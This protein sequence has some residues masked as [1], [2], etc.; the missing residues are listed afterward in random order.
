MTDSQRPLVK[1]KR[2]PMWIIMIHHPLNQTGKKNQREMSKGTDLI[3]MQWLAKTMIGSLK[4]RKYQ[5]DLK[6]QRSQSILKSQ[7]PEN[8][9]PENQTL[10]NQI[11][12]SQNPIT[13]NQKAPINQ[14]IKDQSTNLIIHQNILILN[15]EKIKNK[16]GHMKVSIQKNSLRNIQVRNLNRNQKNL[17]KVDI[18]KNNL[19]NRVKNLNKNLRNN[20]INIQIGIQKKN[21]KKVQKKNRTNNQINI[22]I[23]I[24]A[25]SQRNNQRRHLNIQKRVDLISQRGVNNQRNKKKTRKSLSPKNQITDLKPDSLKNKNHRNPS[26]KN[27]NQRIR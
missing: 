27:Q 6:G 20:L 26:Q 10:E 4:N 19:K 3:D 22:R 18:P 16:G 8:L 2:E 12:K 11:P 1:R 14:R 9:I 24:Q 17:I 23:K 21:L 15:P 25:N 7:N 13:Q 5:R